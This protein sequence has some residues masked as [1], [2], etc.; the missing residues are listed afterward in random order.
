VNR[1]WPLLESEP[2]PVVRLR[3]VQQDDLVALPK[4]INVVFTR[5][6]ALPRLDLIASLGLNGIDMELG[7]SVSALGTPSNLAWTVGGVF[8]MP[9]PNR[10]A[11]GR[12]E[13]SKLEIAQALVNLKRLEQTIYMETDNATGQV[14]TTHKRIEASQ[15]VRVFAQRTLD[16]A[17]SR[18]AAGT[19][20]TF[21]VLQF[22]RDLAQAEANEIR[23]LT[24]H[25][26]A[27]AD[28]ART[29]GTTLGRNAIRL[30]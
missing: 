20:T 7:K 25:M 5:N 30:V 2:V 27:I 12:L 1:R 26:K 17:Q 18:L 9:I 23:A 3:H 4:N 14:D 22:Q 11:R 13:V 24:D 15:S 8:E 29:T 21:E 10:T 19:A 28:Y 16:A 6:Q